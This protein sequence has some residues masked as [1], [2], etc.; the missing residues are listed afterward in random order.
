MTLHPEA[1]ALMEHVAEAGAVPM[2]T[3]GVVAA[4]QAIYKARRLQGARE[5]MASLREMLSDGPGGLIPVRVYRPQPEGRPPLVVYLHGGGWVEG[6]IAASDRWCRSLAAAS[7]CIIASVEYR[8]APE[9]RSPGALKDAYAVT[10]WLADHRGAFGDD[11]GGEREGLSRAE[12]R[13]FWDLYLAERS[14]ADCYVA[15]ARCRDLSALPPALVVVTSHDVLREEG[16]CHARRMSAAGGEVTVVEAEGMVHGFFGQ[17]GAVP[18]A[19]RFLT[20]VSACISTICLQTSINVYVD[21][22]AAGP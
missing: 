7:G 11:T 5:E 2:H 16:L 4:R 14:T 19:R 12:M 13:W 10:G 17:L 9:T 20:K 6:G 18:S 15:P 1:A 8:L 3:M 22:A 21:V